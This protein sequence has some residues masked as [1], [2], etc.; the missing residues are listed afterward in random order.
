MYSEIFLYTPFR[1]E[2]N[3]ILDTMKGLREY[4]ED[5]DLCRKFYNSG[6]IKMV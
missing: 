3:S 6:E 1:K 5:E 2:S 4:Y